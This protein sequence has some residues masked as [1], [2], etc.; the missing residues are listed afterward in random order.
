MLLQ[1]YYYGNYYFASLV[2]ILLIYCYNSLFVCSFF[3][4]FL[5]LPVITLQLY[6][7]K[8]SI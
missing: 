5:Y 6:L 7:H 2:A 3:I 4:Y 1:L 8:T